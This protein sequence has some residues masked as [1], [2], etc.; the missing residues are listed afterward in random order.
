M[1]AFLLVNIEIADYFSALGSTLTFQFSGDFARDMTYSIAWAVFAL[2][3]LV[4][5]I[6]KR[7]RTTRYAGLGLLG[8]T[9]LKLFFHDLATSFTA[10]A[11]LSPWQ[12]SPC[13]PPSPTSAST[14]RASKNPAKRR[15]N[16][17]VK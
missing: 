17:G 14:R 9:I 11:R 4:V 12:P 8:V 7:V 2:V 6:A 10:S 13:W 16:R 5:G 1:L 3:L 15:R